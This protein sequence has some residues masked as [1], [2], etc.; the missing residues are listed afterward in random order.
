MEI[1]IQSLCA[2]IKS[3][4]ERLPTTTGTPIHSIRI[5][6]VPEN[7]FVASAPSSPTKKPSDQKQRRK[8]RRKYNEWTLEEFTEFLSEQAE[9]E[10]KN[11]SKR[12]ELQA[13]IRGFFKSLKK[14]MNELIDE[15]HSTFLECNKMTLGCASYEFVESFA[16]GL[17][18]SDTEL[19]AAL[20]ALS[21]QFSSRRVEKHFSIVR[22]KEI[23]FETQKK[24]EDELK[25]LKKT[26][27]IKGNYCKGSQTGPVEE[28][29]YNKFHNP[30]K[31][32]LLPS[33]YSTGL[34]GCHKVAVNPERN[35]V[36]FILHSSG[37]LI[38]MEEDPLRD[39]VIFNFKKKLD[40]GVGS[41][42]SQ[43]TSSGV[44]SPDCCISVSPSGLHCLL[45][46]FPNKSIFVLKSADGEVVHHWKETALK[47][48]QSA[49]WINNQTIAAA[50]HENMIKIYKV[51]G[52]KN[53]EGIVEL[54]PFSVNFHVFNI[55]SGS[56]VDEELFASGQGGRVSKIRIFGKRVKWEKMPITNEVYAISWAKNTNMVVCGGAG[57]TMAILAGN[58]GEVIAL[59]EGMFSD[60]INMISWSPMEANII[61]GTRKEV[62]LL[63]TVHQ[64]NGRLAWEATDKLGIANFEQPPGREMVGMQVVWGANKMV[65]V[66]NRGD[67]FPVIF[68]EFV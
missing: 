16:N 12:E 59:F 17:L 6:D 60:A 40:V 15:I 10:L 68:D 7:V 26:L 61:V 25:S 42:S 51:L 35:T 2:T 38:G 46:G 31:N 48:L 21:T 32:I 67:V 5:T 23:L 66:N 3:R 50:Y 62:L 8:R 24:I 55:C 11:S 4:I 34:A 65:I 52:G 14:E 20:K 33:V 63:S 19:I 56:E 49:I 39:D 54:R 29:I 44:I 13:E 45:A 57:Q 1:N 18:H 36:C 27:S 41:T 28:R 9:E 53:P 47:A 30:S 37:T 22:V 58:T 43:A 64:E